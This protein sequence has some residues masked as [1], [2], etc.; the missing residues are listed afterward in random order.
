MAVRRLQRD[1]RRGKNG[2]QGVNQGGAK[3]EK[4][5]PYERKGGTWRVLGKAQKEMK[6]QART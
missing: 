5:P 3:K 4:H 1:L 2:V 6:D